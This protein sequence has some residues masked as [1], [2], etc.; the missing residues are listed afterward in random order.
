[1][2]FGGPGWGASLGWGRGNPYW[3]CRFYPWLPRRW[4]AYGVPFWGGYPLPAPDPQA[5]LAALKA[6]AQWLRD[7]LEA[8]SQRIGELGTQEGS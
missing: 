2:W 4:W 8:V 3:F 1:M 6:Q 5:E 7:Q